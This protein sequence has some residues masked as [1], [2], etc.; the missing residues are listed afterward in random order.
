MNTSSTPHGLSTSHPTTADHGPADAAPAAESRAG[1][2]ATGA[3][4]PDPTPGSRAL[5][6]TRHAPFTN[7]ESW[8]LLLCGIDTLDI[9]LEVVWTADWPTT[10]AELELLKQKAAGTPGLL[11]SDQRY[12]ILPSGKPPNYRWHLQWPEFHLFVA[13]GAEPQGPSPNVY[14]SISS[15]TLWHKGLHAAVELVCAEVIQLGGQVRNIKPS[16]CD[17][18][19]DF[20]IPGGLSLEFLRTLR[21]PHHPQHS[22]IMRGDV[23][24]TFYHGA[25]Q[26]P[27][28]LRIYDKAAEIA[29]GGIKYWFY[30][31]WKVLLSVDVWRVEFQLRRETLKQFGINQ[32][33]D[34][35]HHLG[36]LWR[37]LTDDWFS[38]RLPDDTNVSRR[39]IHPWWQTVQACAE[40][41]GPACHL[42]RD[43]TSQLASVDWYVSHCSGCLAG[44]AARLKL[45]DF[46]S[47]AAALTED[48][49]DYWQRKDFAEQL[50]IKSILLGKP[51]PQP[52]HAGVPW[53]EDV[54]L[55]D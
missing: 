37:Y 49:R 48:M 51:S 45:A 5:S 21:T 20:Q 2:P 22:H 53:L 9:G 8:N 14:A 25:K 39:T 23:L 1:D 13:K 27:I 26:S 38:L 11:S 41:F 10:S 46:E 17:L 24:E 44:Y 7:L 40:Q 4:A 47:A 36:G 31:L 18:A 30:D 3:A 28:Q 15:E 32:I 6:V 55:H 50:A 34:L 16:R 19:V 29:A 54:V 35:T 52:T 12:L 33:D 43:N 42:T